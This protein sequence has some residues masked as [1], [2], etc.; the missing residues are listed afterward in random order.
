[1]VRLGGLARLVHPF[2]SLLDAGVAG[3]VAAIAGAG[4]PLVLLL[5]ASMLLLQLAI[6]A[7]ND[8]ADAP[9]DAAARPSKPIPAGLVPRPVAA[10]I[11]AAAATAG[12]L[13]A[14]IAGTGALAVAG[15]GLAA[16]I[17]YDLRL[18]GTRWS[19]VPYSVG[20]P[21]LPLFGWVGATGEVPPALG[22][23]LPVAMLAGAALAVANALADLERDTRAGVETVATVLGVTVARRVGAILQAAVILAALGSAAALGGDPAGMALGVLGAAIVLVGVGLGWRSGDR[24]RQRAWEVQ[25]VGLA[26]LAAGWLGALAAADRLAG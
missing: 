23:L 12:L 19:W 11:A 2:P 25:A 8:W 20:I 9:A 4:P 5:A 26:V 10:W 17:A 24:A 14:A 7:A 6:G 3:A 21:L 16:G 1:M 15:A 18:K 22:V 13:L